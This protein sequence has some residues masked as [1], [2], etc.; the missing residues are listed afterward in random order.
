MHTSLEAYAEAE[1]RLQRAIELDPEWAKPR[2][3]LVQVLSATGRAGEARVA[4]K[5]AVDKRPDDTALRSAYAKLLVE[6]KDYPA[7]LAEYRALRRKAPDDTEIL[8]TTGL[9]AMQAEDWGEAREAWNA[10]ITTGEH[11]DEGRYFLAQT[12]ELADRPEVALELYR[13]VIDGPFRIDA[14]TRLAVLAAKSGRVVEAR[15]RLA[16]LRLVAPDRAVDLYLA[17]ADLLRKHGSPRRSASS[18]TRP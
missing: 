14:G 7:A 16:Q 15:E 12:E 4:L 17:E 11:A 13:Q 18:T 8:L 6:A 3:L 1:P 5:A 9:V 2:L 10:L